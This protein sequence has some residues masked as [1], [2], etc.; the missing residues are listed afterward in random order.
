MKELDFTTEC[1]KCGHKLTI[2]LEEM[3]PGN[4]QNCEVC[5]YPISFE[6]DDAREFSKALDDL[7]H[8]FKDLKRTLK[9]QG[10]K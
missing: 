9:R 10:R 7:D 1:P 5:G 2:K 8:T 3:Y 6:G 4:I